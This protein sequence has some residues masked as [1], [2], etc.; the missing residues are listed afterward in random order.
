MNSLAPTATR[1]TVQQ[2]RALIQWIPINAPGS[3]SLI[4]NNRELMRHSDGTIHAILAEILDGKQALSAF[5]S[6]EPAGEWQRLASPLSSDSGL[7]NATPAT[8][9]NQNGV[10]VALAQDAGNGSSGAIA[11]IPGGLC[12]TLFEEIEADGSSKRGHKGF[13][14]PSVIREE[15]APCLQVGHSPL[16]RRATGA[17]L[18]IVVV[19]A[20]V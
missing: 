7:D 11:Q 16:D 5:G 8:D 9:S 20:H 13:K 1:T 18:V 15:N 19:L 17:D 4:G 6:Q 10:Y 12:E 2:V 3:D 14:R